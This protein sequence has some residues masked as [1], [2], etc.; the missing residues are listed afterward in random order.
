MKLGGAGGGG[1]NVKPKAKEHKIVLDVISNVYVY[2]HV[3]S[4]LKQALGPW[5]A[6]SSC[7]LFLWPPRTRT[8]ASPSSP[9]CLLHSSQVL[10]NY[11]SSSVAALPS[12]GWTNEACT[13]GILK[14]LPR[15]NENTP[16]KHTTTP[17]FLFLGVPVPPLPYSDPPPQPTLLPSQS[18]WLAQKGVDRTVVLVQLICEYTA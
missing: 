2:V 18:K 12:C 8:P 5:L 9:I 13:R 17:R 4:A 6:T 10:T 15:A 11:R 16:H 3:H 1:C 14:S 7:F